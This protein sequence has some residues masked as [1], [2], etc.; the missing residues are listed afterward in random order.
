MLYEE[1]IHLLPLQQVPRPACTLQAHQTHK[2]KA[3]HGQTA[4]LH[5]MT[6]NT[7]FPHSW[8]T[9]YSVKNASRIY[10]LALDPCHAVLSLSPN[11]A[12]EP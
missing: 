5:G 9:P 12:L 8:Q 4:E 6:T 2:H 10:H 7:M 1:Y 11:M 3:K